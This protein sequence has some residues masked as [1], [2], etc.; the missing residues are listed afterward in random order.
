M[1]LS[2]YPKKSFKSSLVNSWW[3]QII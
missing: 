1:Q 3:N 2:M